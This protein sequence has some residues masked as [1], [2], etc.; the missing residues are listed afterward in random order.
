MINEQEV[1][2]GVGIFHQNMTMNILYLHDDAREP[3][4]FF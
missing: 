3:N 1:L 2:R 4:P